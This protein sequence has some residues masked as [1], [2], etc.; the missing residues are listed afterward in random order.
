MKLL[1]ILAAQSP[2]YATLLHRV[3]RAADAQDLPVDRLCAAVECMY[4]SNLHMALEDC[5][6]AAEK[7][8]SMLIR[9]Y[10]S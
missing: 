1:G 10:M 7:N 6:S 4:M 2:Q 9:T 5:V 8:G 3:Y